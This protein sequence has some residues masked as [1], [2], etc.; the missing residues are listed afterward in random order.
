M[1]G[2]RIRTHGFP[3]LSV[4]VVCSTAY[5]VRTLCIHPSPPVSPPLA[6]Q[7]R[8]TPPFRTS[9]PAS[10]DAA[11]RSIRAAAVAGPQARPMLAATPAEPSAAAAELPTPVPVAVAS[12]GSAAACESR[13]VRHV[14]AAAASTVLVDSS[15]RTR[16]G[17]TTSCTA[18]E[19]CGAEQRDAFCQL[20]TGPTDAAHV[21]LASRWHGLHLGVPAV[22]VHACLHG[23]TVVVHSSCQ[24]PR[25]RRCQRR[26]LLGHLAL[27]LRPAAAPQQAAQCC[28]GS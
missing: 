10:A 23:N 2:S 20:H 26:P 19:D 8:C 5:T 21:I 1:E 22:E 17:S 16:S 18:C 15:M 25:R 6:L 4:N 11:T 27:V 28:H 12:L 13:A 9:T 14:C 7:V 3:W 24:G